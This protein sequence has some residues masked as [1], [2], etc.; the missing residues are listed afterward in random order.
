MYVLLQIIA[1]TLILLVA[2][3][4]LRRATRW[5]VWGVF[6][7]MPLILTP[8]WIRVNELGVFSWFK[9]YTVFFCVCWGTALRFTSLGNRAWAR[10]TIPLLLAVNIS[11]AV[12]LDLCGHGSAHTLNAAAGLLLI[13]TL[14]YGADSARIDSAIRWHDLHYGIGRRWV[15][16][17][18]LWNWTFV[19]LNYPSLTGHHTAVLA[20]GLIVAMSDPRRWS[21]TRASTLGVN[22]LFTA[23]SF[24]GMIAWLDTSTWLDEQ[25]GIVAAGFTLVFMTGCAVP[26]CLAQI[27]RIGKDWIHLHQPTTC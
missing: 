20:A 15:V 4:A 2:Q 18:T 8:Y 25:V 27:A 10:S 16:G 21:Q 19:Y 7:V 3:E 12:V 13:A 1:V 17:Y 6:L 22:L 9:Y 5:A 26:I 11:E 24:E 14:P 23:T